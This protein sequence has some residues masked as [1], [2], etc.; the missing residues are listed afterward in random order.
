MLIPFLSRVLQYVK[1][2]LFGPYSAVF[3]CPLA[4]TD[5]AARLIEV[6]MQSKKLNSNTAAELKECYSHL[7]SRD[8]E[9]LWTSGQWMTE[10]T[11]GSDVG[12]TETI[13][14]RKGVTDGNPNHYL[15]YGYKVTTPLSIASHRLTLSS[16]VL[17]ICN[18]L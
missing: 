10:R 15:L 9:T 17:Y 14:T 4:M 6:L 1:L 3:T 7:I 18:A 2:Y 8:P 16:L 5:G 11:G 12:N 13:A